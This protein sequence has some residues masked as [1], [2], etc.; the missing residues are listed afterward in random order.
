MEATHIEKKADR[1]VAVDLTPLRPGGAN[2][3]IKP[4]IFR[5]L[6]EA[7][8]LAGD[9][10]GFVF[11]T[12]S[13]THAEVRGLARRQDIILCVLQDPES[14]VCLSG[15]QAPAEFSLLQPPADLLKVIGVD[16]L[17]APFGA[18]TFHAEG[19]PSMAL[20]VDLLHRDYPHSLT[21]AQI[22][23]REAY[24]AQT[25][26]CASM[27]QCISRSGVERLMAHYQVPEEKLF[28]TYLP[29]H[30]RLDAPASPST[31]GLPEMAAPYFFY[32]ANL[33]KHKN[34]ETLL[35]AY[36]LYRQ[37]AGDAA[38]DL[39]LTFHEDARAAEIRGLARALGL[40][41]YLRCP[42]YVSE[43]GLRT[44]WQHAGALVL[45]SL[46]S[47]RCITACPS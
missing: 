5:M 1:V 29:V 28:Y 40:E 9:S 26:Q 24:I 25:L 13:S 15:A 10:L 23:E 8:R 46:S 27:I 36:R 30:V 33:W 3:G 37:Q 44:L 42:G 34:H 21:S 47:K 18:C 16:L 32:P 31:E 7:Q 41:P 11:L 14:P 45:A 20:I 6:A 12:R 2:G 35:L 22:A 43:A 39:V 38:W 17:Y 19:V 4:A